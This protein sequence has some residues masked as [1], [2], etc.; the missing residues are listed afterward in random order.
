MKDQNLK[1]LSDAELVRSFLKLSLSKAKAVM[2]TDTRKLKKLYP[3]AEAMI[4]ELRLR[5]GDKRR[6][7]IVLYNHPNPQVRLDAATATLAIS[8]EDARRM[9]QMICDRKEHPYALEAGMRLDALDGGIFR[10]T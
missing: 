4:H 2:E 9:L 7:L 6:L 10:P 3:Q 5:E 8:P 1:A